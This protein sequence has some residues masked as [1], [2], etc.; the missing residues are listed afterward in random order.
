MYNRVGGMIKTVFVEKALLQILRNKSCIR[1]T[2]NLST[3]AD[4]STYN[5]NKLNK[6]REENN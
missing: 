6:K 5:K 2:L 4:C 3:C 1:E